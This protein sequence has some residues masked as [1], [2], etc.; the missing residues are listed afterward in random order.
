MFAVA[1]I[2]GQARGALHVFCSPGLDARGVVRDPR[3]QGDP[4][5]VSF[6]IHLIIDE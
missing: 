3:A 5:V 1:G 4:N 6:A 2:T